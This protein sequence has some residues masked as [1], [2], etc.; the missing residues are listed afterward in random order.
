LKHYGVTVNANIQ[1]FYYTGPHTSTLLPQA[2]AL[3]ARL[4][5]VRRQRFEQRVAVSQRALDLAAL[6]LLELGMGRG[7]HT[8]YE[9]KDIEYSSTGG[10]TNK[11]RWPAGH[12]DFSISHAKGIAAC[13]IAVGCKVGADTEDR[14]YIDPHTVRR[15]MST[16]ASLARNLDDSNALSCWTQVEA[17]LKGAGLGVM[18][19]REIEWRE[20][21]IILRGE[22]WW[23]HSIDCGSE[24]VGHVAVNQ[25][26]VSVSVHRIDA[27]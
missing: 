19:G 24:H 18:H 10:I 23:V 3:L 4:N 8:E 25:P 21:A 9:L 7:G 22:R 6:R 15:L 14:R 26:S 17:V 5:S 1:L 11:P 27:L 12:I 16:D 20:D 2:D 13:A